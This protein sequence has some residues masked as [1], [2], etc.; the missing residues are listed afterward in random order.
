M[1]RRISLSIA[2]PWPWLAP[3]FVAFALVLR[4]VLEPATLT[5]M[6]HQYLSVSGVKHQTAQR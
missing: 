3:V 1:R 6:Y 5:S 2:P 4:A